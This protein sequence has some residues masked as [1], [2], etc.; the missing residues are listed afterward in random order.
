MHWCSLRWR[1][2]RSAWSVLRLCSAWIFA[3]LCHGCALT[4]LCLCSVS[5]P[6]FRLSPICAPFL[7][8]LSVS[9]SALPSLVM[10]SSFALAVLLV[11]LLCLCCFIRFFLELLRLCPVCGSALPV[12]TLSFSLSSA[13]FG[14]FV[15]P[16]SPAPLLSSCV[17]LF[18]LLLCPLP[19]SSALALPL[20]LP[21]FVFAFSALK[22][23]ACKGHL[24]VYVFVFLAAG[25]QLLFLWAGWWSVPELSTSCMACGWCILI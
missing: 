11:C 18:V 15:L 13:V 2:G 24:Y 22:L 12:L 10:I 14:F 6:L 21:F 5:V 3:C 23:I 17:H 8:V 16:L 9:A 4:I 20:C 19:F 25:G 7:T 1:P